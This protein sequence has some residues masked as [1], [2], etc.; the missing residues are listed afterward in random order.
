[1]TSR[2][3]HSWDEEVEEDG[4]ETGRGWLARIL[5]VA[6]LVGTGAGS[7]FV[8]HAAGGSLQVLVTRPPPAA[9]AVVEK[10]GG[11]KELDV[12]RQQIV[13]LNQSDQQLLAAQ[14]AEIKRLADQ[15][16]ALSGK[17]ELLQRPVTSAQAS[18]PPAKPATP[19]APAKKKQDAA[20]PEA[21]RR[22]AAAKFGAALPPDQYRLDQ[23]VQPD[24]RELCPSIVALQQRRIAGGF[25]NKRVIH[26]AVDKPP[27]RWYPLRGL[28]GCFGLIGRQ[29]IHAAKRE[30]AP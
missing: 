5:V 4:A 3:D 17:L 27:S 19:P 18:I 28:R 25:G 23:P 9:A 20:K 11:Q 26:P 12:L 24:T 13:T 30:S 7:A 21:A 15:V 2:T 14:Q 10:P 6:L 1:M 22:V 8:W 29:T 16:T